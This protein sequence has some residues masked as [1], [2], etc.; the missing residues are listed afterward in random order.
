MGSGS[1]SRPSGAAENPARRLAIADRLY[2]LATQVVRT[3]PR[4]VSLNALAT[5][6]R[7]ES[8][9][10]HRVGDLATAEGVTQPSMTEL[11]GRLVRDGLAERHASSEDR[12]VV[13]VAI[14]EQGRDYLRERRHVVVDLLARRLARLPEEEIASLE[15]AIPA[16]DHLQQPYREPGA[17]T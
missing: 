14:T 7:L 17:M 13:L 15:A 12:R 11:V 16:L 2:L 5:L 9:G 6:N 1:A 8:T 10:P 4:E 3:A